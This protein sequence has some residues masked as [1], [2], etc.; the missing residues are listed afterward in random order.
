MPP[1]SHV[2]SEWG[3]CHHCACW[4]VIAPLFVV[5]ALSL[6]P[7]HG[8]PHSFPCVCCPCIV[9]LALMVVPASSS[10][11]FM[12]LMFIGIGV[13]WCKHCCCHLLSW[14]LLLSALPS[15]PMSSGSQVGWQH[16]VMWF[17]W[18]HCWETGPIVALWADAHNSSIGHRECRWGG[19]HT[20][21]LSTGKNLKRKRNVSS[22]KCIIKNILYGPNDISHYFGMQGSDDGVSVI[23]IVGV[24][25]HWHWHTLWECGAVGNIIIKR[26]YSK[27]E[28]RLVSTDKEINN[29]MNIPLG[30]NDASQPLGPPHVLSVSTHCFW[31]RCSGYHGW[32]DR[33]VGEV[34]LLIIG[35]HGNHCTKWCHFVIWAAHMTKRSM[36]NHRTI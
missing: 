34:A 12:S 21:S 1:L 27:K 22:K 17:T 11:L 19:G 10:L 8:C 24:G 5:P 23:I 15:P 2:Y 26:L 36:H 13:H 33:K 32:V 18:H 6:S 3:S 28:N 30:P 16:C 20:T 29:T 25:Q 35:G 14:F 9:S 31:G 7:H 4:C